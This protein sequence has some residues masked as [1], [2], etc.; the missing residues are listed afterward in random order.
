MIRT[1]IIGVS[2]YGHQHYSLML[3]AHAEGKVD[4]AGATI[5]NQADEAEKC[6]RLQD[7]GCRIFKDY[8]KMLN[9]LSGSAE[10]C[11]IP[12][13]TPLHRPMTVAALEA[14]MHVLVEKPA[15]GSIKDVRAMR[16]AAEKAKKNVS[17]GYQQMY[18]PATLATK[19]LILNGQIG[20]LSSIKCL[21]MGPRDHA[22]YTRNN[23]AGKLTVNGA[24][25]NDSPF[26]NAFAHD[27]MMMLF[28]TGT[29]ER[30]AAMPVSVE[31]E[32]YRANAIESADTACMRIQTAEGIPVLFYATHACRE[33]FG[34][35]I[36]IRG[37]KGSAVITHTSAVITPDAG[38]PTSFTI[39]GNHQ[40]R[41]AMMASVL[42]AVEGGP[43]FVCDLDT[44]GRQTMLV[45]AIYKNCAIH[46][47]KGQTVTS[48]N[49]STV[50]FIPGIEESMRKAFDS[51]QLLHESGISWTQ[52]P[53]RTG[54]IENPSLT[55]S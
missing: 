31:A 22:Y 3:Q 29:A 8:R 48:G 47:V 50:T 36:H 45:D 20:K 38:E 33:T 6:A 10:F 44:A 24:P 13:G 51:N 25:V 43:S 21:A 18:S 14:G 9:E 49:A 26:N 17:V 42:D 30:V 52:P 12:T 34:P 23:W 16:K 15:A 19:K 40:A 54:R 11:M 32:L 39:K 4:V 41:Q 2:G 46:T 35:E 1:C 53:D 37:T 27:L 28:Q 7:L 5:I 55:Y